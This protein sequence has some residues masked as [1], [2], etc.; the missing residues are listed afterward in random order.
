MCL[1]WGRGLSFWYVG[2]FIWIFSSYKLHGYIISS[3]CSW[4]SSLVFWHSPESLEEFAVR[5]HEHAKLVESIASHS[6]E[7]PCFCHGV[8]TGG[9]IPCW[10][11]L[12][13]RSPLCEMDRVTRSSLAA[14]AQGWVEAKRGAV[15]FERFLSGKPRSCSTSRS[16]GGRC[17]PL[18]YW[19]GGRRVQLAPGY[20][21]GGWR[22]AAKRESWLQ[23][24]FFC[25][26]LRRWDETWLPQYV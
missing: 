19:W 26:I 7:P 14:L 17:R 13:G 5:I 9:F 21:N 20:W 25:F 3:S 4:S 11:M 23:H 1:S 12:N 18:S 22:A 2:V 6:S 8:L 10:D 16:G 15:S 24:L